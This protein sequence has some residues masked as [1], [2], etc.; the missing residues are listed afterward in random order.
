VTVIFGVFAALLGAVAAYCVGFG[1]NFLAR[2]ELGGGIFGLAVGILVGYGTYLFARAAW[3]TGREIRRHPLTS[4][5]RA[6]RRKRVW[7]IIGSGIVLVLNSLLMPMPATA[8]VIGVVVALIVLPVV[9]AV[10]FE[11]SKRKRR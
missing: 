5:E 1:V 8:R 7:S 2:G 10:E 9:L 11:P 6:R 4:P 3:R